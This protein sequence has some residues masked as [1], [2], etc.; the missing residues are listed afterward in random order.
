MSAFQVAHEGVSRGKV[1]DLYGDL[2]ARA[3]VIE[4]LD[5]DRV[6]MRHFAAP[7]TPWFNLYFVDHDLEAMPSEWQDHFIAYSMPFT[8]DMA[9]ALLDWLEQARELAY[10]LVTCEAGQSRSAAVA[11]FISDVKWTRFDSIK[12]KHY[13]HFVYETLMR[14]FA[15]RHPIAAAGCRLRRRILNLLTAPRHD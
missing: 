3:G 10:I 8:A 1:F 14:A 6:S 9:E 13:N 5:P 4:I 2:P 11:R 15:R 7:S 12:G